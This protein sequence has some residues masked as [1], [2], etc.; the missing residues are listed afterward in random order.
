MV[1]GPTIPSAAGESLDENPAPMNQPAMAN[2]AKSP[3]RTD[4]SEV[5]FWRSQSQA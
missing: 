3:S 1:R 2:S 4:H 5:T